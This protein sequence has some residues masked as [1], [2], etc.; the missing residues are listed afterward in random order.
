[1][2]GS[3]IVIWKICK[4]HVYTY[5]TDHGYRK[6][7]ARENVPCVSFS[8]QFSNRVHMNCLFNDY[9]VGLFGIVKL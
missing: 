1:M 3:S 2:T 4:M 5:D 6:Q 7:M 8:Y 9:L